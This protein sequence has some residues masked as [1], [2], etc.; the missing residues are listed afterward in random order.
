M[1]ILGLE[2]KKTYQSISELRYQRVLIFTDADDDGAHICGLFMNFIEFLWPS[3]LEANPD[4]CWL[5]ISPIGKI[6]AT[7]SKGEPTYFFTKQNIVRWR[8]GKSE[9]TLKKTNIKWLKGLASS[10]PKDAKYYFKHMSTF[11]VPLRYTGEESKQMINLVFSKNSGDADLRKEWI[12][13]M[14]D[15]DSE[16]PLGENIAYITW[17]DFFNKQFIHFSVADTV[18]S[19]P[20]VMDGL[21][22][23]QRKILYTMF[24]MNITTDRRLNSLMGSVLERANYHHGD[25]SVTE[26]IVAMAQRH[27]GT[28]NINLLHPSGMFGTRKNPR[29][30]IAS[31]HGAARYI[32][33]RLEPISRNIFN[34]LD[35]ALLTYNEDDNGSPVEPRHY[36]PC[37]PMVLVNGA[38]G[39]GTG[40]STTILKYYPREI[41]EQV[42]ARLNDWKAF[43]AWY[44][45][46]QL[47]KSAVKGEEGK[48]E[49]WPQTMQPWYDGFTGS[50]KRVEAQSFDLIGSL[51]RVGADTIR[52]TE[53]PPEVYTDNW[54]EDI[55][56][57]YLIGASAEQVKKDNSKKKGKAKASA[58]KASAKKAN[59]KKAGAKKAG[60]TRKRKVVVEDMHDQEENSESESKS[61]TSAVPAAPKGK[62]SA[63]EFIKD[64]IEEL[65]GGNNVSVLFKCDPIKLAKL[66][67]EQL[68]KAF[69]LSSRFSFTNVWAYDVNSKLKKF[70]SPEDVIDY[71]CY[72]RFQ[73]YADRKA[74]MIEQ[75]RYDSVELSNKR[76]YLEM[77]GG[78][79]G[80]KP[81]IVGGKTI[82]QV[83]KELEAMGFD[84]LR[85]KANFRDPENEGDDKAS[86]W[87][88][89][90]LL[91][92]SATEDKINKLRRECEEA[93]A[94]LETLQKK[95][96]IDLWLEDLDIFERA[97]NSFVE[98]RREAIE[99]DN[100]EDADQEDKKKKPK[101]AATASKK[102]AKLDDSSAPKRVKTMIKK[103]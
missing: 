92:W 56:K 5:M 69:G 57:K 78:Y 27:I 4:F 89:G 10:D 21:K 12:N 42:R 99:K 41:V 85:L 77:V 52:V 102:R 91:Q 101:K 61:T 86:Y 2:W 63:H 83:E 3:V 38:S 39:I 64:V 29:T 43:C 79:N 94:K 44:E 20:S 40:W 19:L 37:I 90:K 95:T 80:Q 70:T 50:Y 60:A 24:S 67:D 14:Y 8:E 103:K 96:P 16:L 82:Q 35:E 49:A 81:Y 100:E 1:R 11:A 84:K 47:N 65:K 45:H 54:I 93:L 62:G 66:S 72:N 25:A 26:A 98:R 34:P 74:M 9:S 7:T 46:S 6:E 48:D 30:G 76:R 97:Y 33:S 59:A 75:L 28:N 18:R 32:F 31:D 58:K 53:L 88:L 55:K 71:F 51:A 22:P 23:S 73:L 36:M 15:P 87:Y 68:T 13:A 17:P